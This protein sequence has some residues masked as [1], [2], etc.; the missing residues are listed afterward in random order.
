MHIIV[1]S[2]VLAAELRLLNKVV[3]SKPAIAILGHVRLRGDSNGLHLY[4]TDMEVGLSTDCAARIDMPGEVALP[5]AKLLSLVEQFPDADVSMQLDKMHAAVSCGAFKSRLSSLSVTDFPALPEASGTTYQFDAADF[6]TLIARTRYAIN[7]ASSK[8]ILKGALLTMNGDGAAMVATDSRRLALATMSRSGPEGSV[9]VPVKT[10]DVLAGGSE[11]GMMELT[12][13]DRHIF[14]ASS[15][16]LLVSR[17]LEG[18]FPAYERIIPQDNALTLTIDRMALTAALRRI[19]LVSEDNKATYLS[20]SAGQIELTTQS[21][22]VG[23][24][25]E[26]VAGEYDGQP[27]KVCVNAGFVLDFLNAATQSHI[28]LKLKDAKSPLLLTDGDDHI[29]VIMLLKG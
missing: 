3:P 13:S 21:A 27:L 5:A 9:T 7:A 14:F 28:T 8:Y 1:N 4:A 15:G 19:V 22:E 20:L 26:I 17:M 23:A 16:R 24:A 25:S 2:Q 10:L 6:R 29:A 12:V 11:Q 18:K